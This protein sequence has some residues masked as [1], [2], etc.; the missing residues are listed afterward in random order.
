MQSLRAIPAVATVPFFILWFGF[1]ETGRILLFVLGISLNLIVS[2]LQSLQNIDEKYLIAFRSYGME[3]RKL[4]MKILVPFAL[5][6]LLP[7]MRFSL[8]VLIGLSVIAELLGSQSG[9]GYLLQSARTT[10][11][12]DVVVACAILYGIMTITFDYGLRI[13]WAY[14][15]PWVN[16]SQM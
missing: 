14:I 15:V 12:F 8:T 11:S 2:I 10:Y 4:P 5:E 9:L 13:I 6:K 16:R 3:V 7:T 1:S